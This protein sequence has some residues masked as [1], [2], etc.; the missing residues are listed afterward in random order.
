MVY[1]N[2]EPTKYYGVRDINEKLIS[3]LRV[4]HISGVEDEFNELPPNLTH[5]SFDYFFDNPIEFGDNNLT[6]ILFGD[7]FNSPIS[8]LPSSLQFLSLGACYEEDLP[9]FPHSLTE[10]HLGN[11]SPPLLSIP[12][13]LKNLVLGREY[14]HSL[15]PPPSSLQSITFSN[16]HL[17]ATL[18][19]ISKLPSYAS[20]HL[21]FLLSDPSMTSLSSS[22]PSQVK[23]ITITEDFTQPITFSFPPSLS[24]LNVEKP[25]TLPSLPSSLSILIGWF[26][27]NNEL[28]PNL[29]YLKYSSNATCSELP[30]F[31]STIK[32]FSFL[33]FSSFKILSLYYSFYLYSSLLLLI[34]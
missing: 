9:S 34:S 15:P 20:V 1:R 4:T 18:E 7:C 10:L 16:V 12:I 33:S 2:Y 29:T 23:K 32:Y 28:P 26:D 13:G 19:F 31:P 3:N 17:P 30:V 22:L 8:N 25:V 24:Q 5:L 11:L 6:H 14:T 21:Y 27:T